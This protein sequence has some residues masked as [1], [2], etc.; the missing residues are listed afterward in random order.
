MFL[1][2]QPAGFDDLVR[3]NTRVSLCETTE[4]LEIAVYHGLTSELGC[5]SISVRP[6]RTQAVADQNYLKARREVGVSLS[7]LLGGLFALSLTPI[8]VAI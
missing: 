8:Y 2:L 4:T 3:L 6:W 7:N 1:L 5:A